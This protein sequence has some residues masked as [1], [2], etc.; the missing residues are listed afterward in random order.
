MDP[1]YPITKKSLQEM[2]EEKR[3]R[4]I[5]KLIDNFCM[6]FRRDVLSAAQKGSDGLLYNIE[7]NQVFSKIDTVDQILRKSFPDSYIYINKDTRVIT[8][9]WE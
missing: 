1:W 4:E 9:S 6:N 7:D 2:C 5:Q 8:I 3:K